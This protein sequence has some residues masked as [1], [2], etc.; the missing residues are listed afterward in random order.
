MK[1]LYSFIIV[2]S[3]LNSVNG[4]TTVAPY[5]KHVNNNPKVEV[6]FTN[7][8]KCNDL[9]KIKQNLIEKGIS[10]EYSKL[11]FDKKMQLKKIEFFC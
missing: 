1:Q 7:G 10:I 2:A 9:V 6:V 8:L 4:F 11:E 5:K 3:V